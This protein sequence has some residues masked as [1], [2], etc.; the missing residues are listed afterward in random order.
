MSPEHSTRR[1]FAKCMRRLRFPV[2]LVLVMLFPFCAAEVLL[3]S[4]GLFTTYN[5]RLGQRFVS[6]YAFENHT[7]WLMRHQPN[8]SFQYNLPEF[9]FEVK[10]N[11]EG[12]RDVEHP[13]DKPPDEYRIVGLGDSFTEGVGAAYEDTYLKV[14]ERR[15]NLGNPTREIRTICGGVPGSDP[16]FSYSLLNRRLLKYQPDFIILFLNR[17]DVDDIIVRGGLDRFDPE[18]MVKRSCAPGLELPFRHSHLFRGILLIFGGYDFLYLSPAQQ[19]MDR[20]R[21]FDTILEVARSIRT[22]GE[23]SG[24]HLLVTTLSP[25]DP[26]LKNTCRFFRPL[27]RSLS[28]E[29]IVAVD[30]CDAM[31]NEIQDE[32]RFFEYFWPLDCHCTAKGY[33]V[34]ARGIEQK[35]RAAFHGPEFPWSEDGDQVL[36]P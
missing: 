22:L 31:R 23:K 16:V 5:E 7:P 30:L 4:M 21:A 9:D 24:F 10:T 15:L 14:L 34:V 20:D 13:V 3:R 33:D 25:L 19:E 17:G 18:G 36:P 32:S 6:P 27:L 11:S 35:L 2:V 12:M 29:N 1:F 8:T 28:E 26:K